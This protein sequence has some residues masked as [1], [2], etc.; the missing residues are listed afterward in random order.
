MTP[1]A[2]AQ[3]AY[4]EPDGSGYNISMPTL[5]GCFTWGATGDNA[6]TSAEDAIAGHLAARRVFGA[7]I[8][9][10]D[11]P[12]VDRGNDNAESTKG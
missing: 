2:S 3:L 6:R 1:I 5:P 4:D 9:L 10:E 7:P 12:A 8:P 11:P